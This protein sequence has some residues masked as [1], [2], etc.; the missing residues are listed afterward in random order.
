MVAYPLFIFI[1]GFP[2]ARIRRFGRGC[3][4]ACIAFIAFE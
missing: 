4:G 2:G 1:F 3:E